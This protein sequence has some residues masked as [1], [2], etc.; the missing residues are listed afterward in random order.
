MR[1]SLTHY[2]QL[3]AEELAGIISPADKAEL[4]AAKA[5]IPEVNQLWEERHALFAEREVRE[6]ADL[7][8]T[9]PAV[10]RWSIPKRYKR[11]LLV[12]CVTII[13]S[14]F[15]YKWNPVPET[16]YLAGNTIELRLDNGKTY[17]LSRIGKI[18][19]DLVSL[20][21]REKSLIINSTSTEYA[22]LI[23]PEGKKYEVKLADTT[24]VSLNSASCLRFPLSFKADKYRHVKASGEAYFK[25]APDAERPFSVIIPEGIIQVLGTEFNVKNY[26]KKRSQVALVSGKVRLQEGKQTVELRPGVAGTFTGKGI[27]T[28]AFI[29]GEMLSW[30]N[31]IYIYREETL[32]EVFKVVARWT[33]MKVVFVDPALKEKRYT[34]EFNH[35]LPLEKFF[36]S[37]MVH[38]VKCTLDS[39]GIRVGGK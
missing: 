28:A 3:I 23:V 26:D 31:G 19:D 25:V 2:E 21:I 11:A 1:E 22:T 37:M 16:G 30:R 9:P 12:A 4:D 36:E 35:N 34:G 8:M 24:L 14:C 13:F 7:E 38:G 27:D 5:E 20:D 18:E 39:K 32:E 6:W 29:P 15:L 33:G 10:S 17:D